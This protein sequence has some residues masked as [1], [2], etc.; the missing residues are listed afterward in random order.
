MGIRLAINWQN[1]I[2]ITQIDMPTIKVVKGFIPFD[3]LKGADKTITKRIIN[4]QADDMVSKIN[5]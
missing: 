3:F 4:G 5:E 1:I 2:K